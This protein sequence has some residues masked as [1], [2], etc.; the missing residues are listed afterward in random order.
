[1]SFT[2]ER[3]ADNAMKSALNASAISRARVVLPTPGG[4]QRII[5]CGL[6][7]AKA[8][9]SG[10]PGPSRCCCPITSPMLFGRNLSASGVA[11]LLTGNRSLADDIGAFRRREV[12][13]I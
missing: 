7:D 12:E 6:R 5:E 10:F 11:G 2:P 4:P 9:A 8:M 3:T 13:K 1:M